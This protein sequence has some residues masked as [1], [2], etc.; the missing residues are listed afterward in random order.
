MHHLKMQERRAFIRSKMLTKV[1]IFYNARVGN[2]KIQ[3]MIGIYGEK[4]INQNDEKLI[5]FTTYNNLRITDT[6]F[7]HKNCL[8]LPGQLG[9]QDLYLIMY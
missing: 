4:I 7:K 5:D 9:T 2:H 6:L 8:S 1:T 3:F